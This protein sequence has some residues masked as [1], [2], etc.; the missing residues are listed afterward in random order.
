MGSP[1]E[2]PQHLAAK[3][4]TIRQ[5]LGLS[6]S[7]MVALLNFKVTG[8]RIS[9]YE[10]GTREPNLIVLLSYAKSVG[11]S[12]DAIIDDDLDLFD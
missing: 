7:E 1:R 5:K 3:L 6:Q 8:A 10:H 9:E 2:K 12:V 4:L 11:V